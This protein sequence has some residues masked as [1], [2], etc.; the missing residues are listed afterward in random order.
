M[1]LRLMEHEF[2]EV[3]LA[4]SMAESRRDVDVLKAKIGALKAAARDAEDASAVEADDR[5]PADGAA[6]EPAYSSQLIEQLQLDMSR[7]REG[8][9][10]D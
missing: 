2:R 10:G 6:E 1:Q 5:L 8:T 4:I 3:E 9:C 7:V